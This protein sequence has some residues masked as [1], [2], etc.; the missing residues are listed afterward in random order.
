MRGLIVFGTG[1]L[2]L[3]IL[4]A[5][6]ARLL[7]VGLIL[8]FVQLA[9]GIGI[10]VVIAM[11]LVA[12][13]DQETS[14]FEGASWKLIPEILLAPI[15]ISSVLIF[16]TCIPL[17]YAA[18]F[19]QQNWSRSVVLFRRQWVVSS[20]CAVIVVLASLFFLTPAKPEPPQSV[21]LVKLFKGNDVAWFRGREVSWDSIQRIESTA[22]PVHLQIHSMPIEL[23]KF[24]VVE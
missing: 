21:G 23:H 14:P 24:G 10:L 18:K 7:A 15:I 12:L 11:G 9:L 6:T 16:V 19:F 13:F 20:A 22:R 3:W 5:I 4:I 17:L 1:V 2:W 8:G